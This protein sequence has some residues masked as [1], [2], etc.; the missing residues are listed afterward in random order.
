MKA[1]GVKPGVPDIVI[2]DPPPVGGYVGAVVELK[3]TVGGTVSDDQRAWLERFHARNWAA[4]VA[5]GYRAA[6]TWLEDLGY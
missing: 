3:K 5:E 6:R 2:I 4:T 1:A